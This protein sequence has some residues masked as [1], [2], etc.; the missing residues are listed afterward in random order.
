MVDLADLGSCYAA[1]GLGE[2]ATD[3]EIEAAYHDLSALLQSNR[4]SVRLRRWAGARQ[5]EADAAYAILS[6][7]GRRRSLATAAQAAGPVASRGARAPR[8]AEEVPGE[9]A[10]D[11]RTSARSVARARSHPEAR[12]AAAPAV[13]RPLKLAVLGVAAILVVAAGYMVYRSGPAGSQP[14]Q[15]PAAPVASAPPIT[16]LDQARV[17][18]LEALVQ[19]N[20]SDGAALFELGESHF[21]AA[22]WQ[23]SIDWFTRLVAVEPTNIHALTDIGTANFDLG[24]D[25]AAKAAWMRALAVNPNDPQVHYN[26]GFL[27]AQ[28]NPPDYAAATAEWET[29]VKLDPNSSL[30]QVA[31][32][33]L[34][35]LKTN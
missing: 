18:E 27:Y 22:E 13:S 34:D 3:A 24:N 31:K 9:T 15:V 7:S 35:G 32:M 16:P 11:G 5:E 26:L 4:V 10:D 21:Q 17:A 20:P 19:K 2:S 23:K 12:V 6:D 28:S 30:G 8:P 14:A 33:H 29:V 25:S 1:L